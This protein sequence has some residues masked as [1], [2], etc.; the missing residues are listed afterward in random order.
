MWTFTFLDPAV[1]LDCRLAR[2]AFKKFQDWS[3]ANRYRFLW[4]LERGR[5]SGHYHYHLVSDQWWSAELLWAIC[6]R[7][8][9]GQIDVNELPR[10]RLSYVAK[11]LGKQRQRWPIPRGVRLWGCQGFK[12]VKTNSIQFRETTLTV[13]EDVITYP[14]RARRDWIIDGHI[15][16]T[17]CFH[18]PPRS[19]PDYLEY[20]MN[21]TKE[22][23]LH[24]GQ[25]LASGNILAVGEYRT[26]KARKLDFKDKDTGEQK[27]RKIVEHGIEVGEKQ[28]TVTEWLPDTADI[29]TVKSPV[30]K[31]EPVVVEV[32]GFSRQYGITAASVKSLAS[33]NGKLA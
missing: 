8:G 14:Y 24:L 1:R 23:V 20:K 29:S 4:V 12:G 9:I 26:C 31:G 22:N 15:V 5:K 16:V 30:Q 17:H 6:P 11:Y 28:L 21:I 27:S 10:H 33:F 18:N 13:L 25:L 2:V 19:G 3:R 32:S 7:F